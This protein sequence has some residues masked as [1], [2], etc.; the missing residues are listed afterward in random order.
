MYFFPTCLSINLLK[1]II[2]YFITDILWQYSYQSSCCSFVS[3]AV[4][5]LSS[6]DT[7]LLAFICAPDDKPIGSMDEKKV[8]VND[9]EIR[10]KT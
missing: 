2:S 3:V 7:Q 8:H 5:G 9:A 6:P 10:F 1:C 4:K